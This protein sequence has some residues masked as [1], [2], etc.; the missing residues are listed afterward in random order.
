MSKARPTT[1]AVA[2]A[3]ASLSLA[4]CKVHQEADARTAERLVLV[5][6][7]EA[8]P[9]ITHTYTGLVAARVQSDL[10]FR[11]PGKVIER[12]VDTGEVV[13][14]GQP[15]MRIDPT[16]YRSRRHGTGRRRGR[17]QGATGSR[18]RPMSGATAAWSL[19]A[20]SRKSAYDQVKA[21]ADSARG[22]ADRRP[23]AQEQVAR[24]QDDYA[25]LL[26]DGDGTV[27]ETLA[28]PGQ[29]VAAGQ[30]VVR[31]AH[32]G[33]REAVVDLP[34]TMRP[35]IGN[36]AAG[37]PLWRHRSRLRPSSAA[38]GLRRSADPDLRGTLCDGRRRRPRAAR[39]DRHAHPERY[40]RQV[41][42]SFR[43]HSAPSTTKGTG[44]GVWVLDRQTSRVT[45]RP[46]QVSELGG[47]TTDVMRR[48]APR[49]RVVATGGHFLHEGEH[50]A[51]RR[52]KGGDAMS[53]FNLS[54]LAVR[55]R[56][57]TLFLIVVLTLVGVF[58][59]LS[60][61]RAEDPPFTVKVL[62][63]IAA[64]PGATAE[65]MQDLVADPLEKRMQ[66]LQ[67]Y[68]RV[69]TFTR[70]GLAVMMVTL[71]RHDAAARTCRSNSTRRARSSATSA[72]N[73]PAGV[74]G[75]FINDE[76][77][78]VDFAVYALEGHGMP[79]RLLVASSGNTAPAPAA[80]AGRQEGRHP[81]RAARTHLR[82]VLLCAAGQSRRLARRMSS[83]LS[84]GRMPSRR[85]GRS[86]P[87][88]RRCSCA[89]TARS[90]S[91]RRSGTRRSSRAAAR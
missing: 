38:V 6:P 34:E 27:V 4:A 28:E 25:V 71:Q 41:D 39:R 45:F 90:T 86:I 67:W 66:E 33:P 76:Y 60:L 51:N 24:N 49:G 79:E 30:T 61:G 43:C 13:R 63:V 3:L 83:P 50:V 77:S 40:A 53:G 1:L 52:R 58:A 69:E 26:A 44:A 21:A 22:P 89:S 15:L 81:G 8:S 9:G 29:V 91:C 47:E 10:G 36:P 31:L 48:P 68:D 57:I 23:Q 75:P 35:A 12:L 73:L 85:P 64:W 80:R 42:D 37:Q 7:V 14:A 88:V 32:A 78:D 74:L 46:V 87:A 18:P 59:Y 20:L 17:G 5:T 2:A 82:Q 72:H 16:D 84:H 62:T 11:V 19:P 70:P 55:E 56:S 65:E 54:A